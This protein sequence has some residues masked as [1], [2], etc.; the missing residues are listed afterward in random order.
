MLWSPYVQGNNPR[1]T[2]NRRLG[3]P[4][5]GLGSFVKKTIGATVRRR[6]LVVQPGF[7]GVLINPYPNLLP[8]VFFDGE[9]ISF[10]VS[11]VIY[12][13]STNNPPIVI[14]N[15]IYEHQNFLSL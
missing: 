3:G 7:S 8:D 1:Y 10:D 4:G 6:S 14:I 11:L 12:I 13:S 5:V 15:R 2:L 9:I